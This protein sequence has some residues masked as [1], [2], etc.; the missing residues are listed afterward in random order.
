MWMVSLFAD[1]L[2]QGEKAFWGQVT[3]GGA[4]KV[5]DN[6]NNIK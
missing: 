5:S 2:A 3:T 1:H 4:M 6:L